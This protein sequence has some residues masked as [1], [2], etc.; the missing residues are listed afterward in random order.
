VG[1]AVVSY[2]GGM[3]FGLNADERSTQDLDVLADGIEEALQGLTELAHR[4]PSVALPGSAAA[5]RG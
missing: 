5:G 3:F 1:V 2:D 4:E